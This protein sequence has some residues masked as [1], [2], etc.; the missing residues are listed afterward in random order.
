MTKCDRLQCTKARGPFSLIQ[1]NFWIVP[2]S[3]NS[4]CSCSCVLFSGT[5]C[6]HLA[7]FLSLLTPIRGPTSIP[8]P[9]SSPPVPY[10]WPPSD[11]NTGQLVPSGCL[12][13][14]CARRFWIVIF[15][16]VIAASFTDRQSATLTLARQVGKFPECHY[17][18]H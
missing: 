16:I 2:Q 17:F 5:R 9:F 18:E 7:L 13:A 11:T 8:P 15:W 10:S 12:G 3:E 4:P 1:S 6:P 14:D